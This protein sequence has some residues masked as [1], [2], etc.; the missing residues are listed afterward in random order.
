MLLRGIRIVMRAT[1]A[2]R[3]L[4]G[5]E[6]NKMDAVG[7]SPTGGRRRP[8]R[9]PGGRGQISAGC[10]KMLIESLLGEQIPEVA[11][12]S[13]WGVAVYNVGTLAQMGELLPLGRGLIERVVTVSGP[14]VG[15]PATTWC[16]S[17]RRSA[18]YSRS[19]P[20]QRPTRS[21]SAAR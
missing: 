8:D 12:R 5:I 14:A 9:R 18:F 1:G 6:D 16:R 17:V 11:C 4:I 3:A 10:G 15:I 13:I 19:V 2:E 7:R 21:F 20:T